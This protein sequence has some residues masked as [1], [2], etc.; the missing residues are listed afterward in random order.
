MTGLN[1]FSVNLT[2]VLLRFMVGLAFAVAASSGH[3]FALIGAGLSV[4]AILQLWVS[5]R[6][7]STGPASVKALDASSKVRPSPAHGMPGRLIVFEGLDGSSKSTQVEMLKSYFEA[8]GLKV[9]LTNWNYSP[10]VLET[11]KRLKKAKYL[12]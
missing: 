4:F 7:A 11:I 2:S 12:V 3:A 8:Q 6:L 1:R 9:V 5:R 10:Y